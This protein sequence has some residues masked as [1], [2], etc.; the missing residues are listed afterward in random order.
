VTA[1]AVEAGLTA[2]Q[3]LGGYLL[4]VALL[5]GQ[6][7]PLLGSLVA[8]RSSSV[9]PYTGPGVGVFYGC[10]ATGVLLAV[11]ALVARQRRHLPVR[12]P[13]GLSSLVAV[14]ALAALGF[15][16]YRFF[17]GDVMGSLHASYGIGALVLCS[18]WAAVLMGA[19]WALRTLVSLVQWALT[20]L[21]GTGKAAPPESADLAPAG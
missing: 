19:A 12:L 9:W 14:L 13:R 4:F 7:G 1:Y 5:G 6:F 3:L 2:C 15:A 17:A 16:E 20:G 21:R 18:Q 8:T 11:G 10:V